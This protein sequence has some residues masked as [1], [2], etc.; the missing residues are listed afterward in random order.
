MTTAITIQDYDPRWP[1]Q[2]AALRAQLATV[3]D[4]LAD[5][6]EHIGSTAIPGLAAKPIID[7]DILLKSTSELPLVIAKLASLG[8][9]HQGDLGIAGR[10][11]FR[12]LKNDIAHHLYVCPHNSPE[13]ARHIAF[14]DY[15]RAHIEDAYAYAALKRELAAR[16]AADR[17]A[18]TQAKSEFVEK[19]LCSS[20][21]NLSSSEK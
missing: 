18:Y 7:I 10:E 1:A 17:D 12:T 15:L 16:F 2:F 5:A 9:E 8:Y 21:Q 6:I 13:Y 19:I 14:R 3:L 4:E 11:A 20:R